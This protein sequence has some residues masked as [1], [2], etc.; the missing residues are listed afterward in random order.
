MEQVAQKRTTFTDLH[1]DIP[2]ERLPNYLN[3]KDLHAL[4]Q[5]CKKLQK[6]VAVPARR[7]TRST[8]DVAWRIFADIFTL[9][10]YEI[11]NQRKFYQAVQAD[12][13]EAIEKRWRWGASLVCRII[14]KSVSGFETIN[15]W[16]P[17]IKRWVGANSK[18]LLSMP[19]RQDTGYA[20][21]DS[22]ANLALRTALEEEQP[23]FQLVSWI[24]ANRCSKSVGCAR[25][26]AWKTV[27]FRPAWPAGL[28]DPN[29]TAKQRS[30]SYTIERQKFS[31][32][33]HIFM[34]KLAHATPEEAERHSLKATTGP[35][36]TK[37]PTKTNLLAY[38]KKA[39]NED[40]IN[41]L[42]KLHN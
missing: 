29:E 11:Y 14:P 20:I 13:L 35:T 12:D 15:D 23:N 25:N 7:I 19:I 2:R 28:I 33:P 38:A 21:S 6:T 39:K 16:T 3:S 37:D 32:N 41:Y 24:K 18:D 22:F 8:M 4:R 36:Y 26:T 17:H 10:A 34:Q 9:G 30:N 40:L 42:E 27:N 31:H 5:T 1:N